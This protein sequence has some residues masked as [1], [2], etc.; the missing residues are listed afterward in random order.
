MRLCKGHHLNLSQQGAHEEHLQSKLNLFNIIY[1]KKNIYVQDQLDETLSTSNFIT[2]H[3]LAE[4]FFK[5]F[6]KR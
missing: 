4:D 3:G 5:N 1:H 2:I 6:D